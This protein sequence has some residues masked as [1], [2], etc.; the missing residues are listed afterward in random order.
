MTKFTLT[1]KSTLPLFTLASAMSLSLSAGAEELLNLVTD[2]V[3][4]HRI[5]HA[6]LL[7]RG[8]DLSGLKARRLGLSVDGAPVQLLAKG[9]DRQFG[10]TSVFGQGSYIEFYAAGIDSL[11]SESQVFTVHY[12]SNAELRTKRKLIRPTRA[13]VNGTQASSQVYTHTER[14]ERD[15]TYSFVSPSATDPWHFG[16]TFSFRPT[17]TYTFNLDNVVGSSAAAEIKAQMYGFVN[18]DL[19][20][21]NGVDRNDH[22]YEVHVNDVLVGDQQFDGD[23]ATVFTA[24]NVN[25]VSGENRFKYNYRPVEGVPF[26]RIALNELE[27][28]YPRTTQAQEGYLEGWFDA[29]QALVTGL[30]NRKARVY[31]KDGETISRVTG[32]RANSVGTTFSTGGRPGHYIVVN[33]DVGYRLPT[34]Q[35]IAEQENISSGQ[36][37]YLVIAHPSLMGS[38]LDELVAL[39]SNTYRVKVVDVNQVYA[40]Y[41]NHNVGSAAIK[42][43]V[44]HAV[45]NMQTQYVLLLGNDSYDYKNHQFES[46]S[47][48]PTLYAST[49]AGGL[50]VTQTPSDAAYGDVNNDQVPDVAVGRISARTTQELGF[51]VDKIQAY[52]ARQDYAGRILVA[53]DK[54]DLGNGINFTRDAS[55]LIE[56]MPVE[57]RNSLRADFRAF[58]EQDGH[59]QA[60]DK[61]ATAMNAGVSVVSYIGHSSQYSWAYTTPPL[62]AVGEIDSLSNVGKPAVVTQWG[63]WNTYYVDPNGNT[64]GDRFL[65]GGEFGAVTVLGA[66]TLTSSSGERALGIELNKRMFERGVTLGD[67]IIAAKQALAEKEDYPAI[68]LGWQILGDPAIVISPN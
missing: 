29:R 3:G 31:R 14:I 4:M 52:A 33:P 16:S 43:Y 7:E 66:S 27:V 23:T 26:D 20:D 61:L 25:V 12:L 36:A 60:H 1:T 21:E 2:Q 9:Q 35:A 59:Q 32:A 18:F 39:R 51:V 22:H 64:M 13:R 34:V 63:C 19:T 67:A 53:A 30:G 6:Q 40:Q 54:D 47:L 55:D 44:E 46:V 8:V 28:S 5:T 24:E 41:G 58:P 56:A 45:A 37:E 50:N 17:P 11:Y 68:Q 38:E 49:P 10:R 57:W 62:L 65:V 48:I 15:N 42:A